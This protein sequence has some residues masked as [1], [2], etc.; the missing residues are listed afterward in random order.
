[1]I[2]M[3]RVGLIGCGLQ[4]WRRARAVREHGDKPVIIADIDE[5]KAKA[6]A[7]EMRC[8]ATTNW[9]DVITRK[10]VDIVVVCTPNHLH[11]PIS[12]AALKSKKHVLCEKPLGRNPDEAKKL[13]DIA[14]ESGMKLKCGL[15][16]R[17][18]PGIRQARKW[19]DEGVIG[20]LTFLRC[21]Y[22]ICGRPGYE[23]E[24][25]AN[26]DMAG[27]GELLDQGIHVLDLF[28]WFAGDFSQ[29]VGF[30]AT[31]F[32]DT[33]PLEDNAFAI[34]RT[35]KGQIATLHVSW[36]QWKN[37]FSFEVFGKEGYAIVEGLGGSYGIERATLG[38]R[39][40]LEPFKEEIVEFRG[41]D[42]S[43]LQEWKEF[44]TTLRENREPMGNGHD[45]W[46]AVELAYAIYQSARRHRVVKLS[47]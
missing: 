37:L 18:H 7:D 40:F 47:G 23:S 33:A 1:M 42:R 34:L 9:E 8:K 31:M 44:V 35:N 17:H 11:A 3:M 24:W 13:V 39:S 46:K 45:G 5:G 26:P 25:R 4:G 27:G 10:D 21:R 38:R 12:V 16:L 36:T 15:N 14:K 2:P 30:I 19:F 28:R 22:G 29:V 43:W 20:E 32:W 6:L 41:E